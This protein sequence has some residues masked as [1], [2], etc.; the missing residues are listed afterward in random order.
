MEGLKSLVQALSASQQQILSPPGSP[1]RRSLAGPRGSVSMNAREKTQGGPRSRLRAR[2]LSPSPPPSNEASAPASPEPHLGLMRRSSAARRSIVTLYGNAAKKAARRKRS[3]SVGGVLMD[4]AKKFHRGEMDES[5]L[6]EHMR[7]GSASGMLTLKRRQS[8]LSSC[9]IDKIEE[10]RKMREEG[11]RRLAKIQSELYVAE[12]E[13]SLR[14]HQAEPK[15]EKEKDPLNQSQQNQTEGGAIA[16]FL[17]GTRG[18]ESISAG[19]GARGR[20]S[21]SAGG[22]TRGRGRGSVSAGGGGGRASISA[23]AGGGDVAAVFAQTPPGGLDAPA[24]SPRENPLKF[25]ARK[26]S[27]S[28]ASPRGG[29]TASQPVR[30]GRTGSIAPVGGVPG[31][32]FKGGDPEEDAASRVVSRLTGRLQKTSVRLVLEEADRFFLLNLNDQNSAAPSSIKYLPSQALLMTLQREAVTSHTAVGGDSKS[33]IL[34]FYQLPPV[35][36]PK[37]NPLLNTLWEAVAYSSKRRQR[38][39]SSRK[40]KIKKRGPGAKGGRGAPLA[41]A[42]SP[43]NAACLND[44]KALAFWTPKLF[45]ASTAHL[46]AGCARPYPSLL[47][48][49][50]RTTARDLTDFLLVPSA[51]LLV[52]VRLT[53]LPR[54]FFPLARENSGG[55]T[56]PP[57]VRGSGGVSVANVPRSI[58]TLGMDRSFNRGMSS[59]RTPNNASGSVWSPRSISSRTPQG[60]ASVS[61]RMSLGSRSKSKLMGTS[62]QSEGKSILLGGTSATGGLNA[63]MRILAE[64]SRDQAGG[65]GGFSEVFATSEVELSFVLWDFS[66]FVLAARDGLARLVAWLNALESQK[67]PAI[68]GI[69]RDA[70]APSGGRFLSASPHRGVGFLVDEILH[71]LQSEQNAARREEGEGSR[72]VEIFGKKNADERATEILVSELKDEGLRS[73]R[74]W[75]LSQQSALAKGRQQGTEETMVTPPSKILHLLTGPNRVSPFFQNLLTTV[76]TDVKVKE[77]EDSDSD[78]SSSEGDET[79]AEPQNA[80]PLMEVLDRKRNRSVHQKPNPAEPMTAMTPTLAVM[81]SLFKGIAPLGCTASFQKLGVSPRRGRTKSDARISPPSAT[82][83]APGG[84]RTNLPGNRRTQRDPLIKEQ[85]QPVTALQPAPCPALASSHKSSRSVAAAMKYMPSDAVAEEW[86]P[87][88]PV[89]PPFE[90]PEPHINPSSPPALNFSSRP[91]S[92]S[93]RGSRPGTAEANEGRESKG[94]PPSPR[95]FHLSPSQRHRAA[96]VSL[97]ARP[98]SEAMHPP[99]EIDD[100]LSRSGSAEMDPH[101]LPEEDSRHGW[102]QEGRERGEARIGGKSPPRA[103]TTAEGRSEERGLLLPETGEDGGGVTVEEWVRTQTRDERSEGQPREESNER[104]EAKGTD[105]ERKRESSGEIEREQDPDENQYSPYPSH[106]EEHER[107]WEGDDQTEEMRIRRRQQTPPRTAPCCSRTAASQTFRH[108]TCGTATRIEFPFA[109]LPGPQSPSSLAPFVNLRPPP[110]APPQRPGTPRAQLVRSFRRSQMYH[111]LNNQ[112]E[113]IRMRSPPACKYENE[114]QEDCQSEAEGPVAVDEAITRTGTGGPTPASQTGWRAIST[115]GGRSTA[116]AVGGAEALHSSR[117]SRTPMLRA[118]ML[119][120][121]YATPPASRSRHTQLIERRGHTSRPQTTGG[122]GAAA[123][124]RRRDLGRSHPDSFRSPTAPHESAQ[125][126]GAVPSPHEQFMQTRMPSVAFRLPQRER[127]SQEGEASLLQSVGACEG[128]GQKERPGHTG[129]QGVSEAEQRD[130]PASGRARSRTKERMVKQTSHRLLQ[131]LRGNRVRR[132]QQVRGKVE[133]GGGESDRQSIV[134]TPFR[135]YAATPPWL[136]PEKMRTDGID[137][138]PEGILLSPQESVSKSHRDVPPSSPLPASLA[139]SE[140]PPLIE[141]GRDPKGGSIVWREKG[142]G[143]KLLRFGTFERARSLGCKRPPPRTTPAFASH[144]GGENADRRRAFDGMMPSCKGA[145]SPLSGGW[146]ENGDGMT[147]HE[148]EFQ[149]SQS[150]GLD[151]TACAPAFSQRDSRPKPGRR[152]AA[153]SLIGASGSQFCV[154]VPARGR[155]LI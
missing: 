60:A 134:T 7:R 129:A 6:F 16:A 132:K 103:S 70:K 123:R 19:G 84:E 144:R 111:R 107:D 90:V 94:L 26:I 28:A 93:M 97:D 106:K 54:M 92:P 115:A 8:L 51:D 80:K 22:G 38:L 102:V 29:E 127:G 37:K 83:T 108:G 4:A 151:P 104:M 44:E 11:E 18:R 66:E 119:N 17:G 136:S 72:A 126:P 1:R 112:A 32:F 81:D 15:M 30:R 117:A 147:R 10:D 43:F 34:T 143:Q 48:V 128:N 110:T 36:D 118:L 138:P 78:D 14:D 145:L 63:S 58:E 152:V 135:L 69:L 100:E 64:G 76:A 146:R 82:A 49:V 89:N 109:S 42:S 46:H 140:R 99:S 68:G 86:I 155:S 105:Q 25:I 121:L 91:S 71:I 133:G 141:T 85:A 137:T 57:G 116:G 55:T 96:S 75:H 40:K 50:F 124:S 67:I 87:L 139:P 33:G 5:S 148:A 98:R 61:R 45:E 79:K 52:T 56:G 125:S 131:R 23:A 31:G 20:G 77:V 74:A 120:H 35:T 142:G 39:S 47:P 13:E 21:I 88:P 73:I 154:S 3:K 122:P 9:Y 59:Q 24:G 95:C 12:D 149:K 2:S 65:D 53:A 150:P 62:R 114:D 101:V 113:S 27:V 130:S 41:L 153:V